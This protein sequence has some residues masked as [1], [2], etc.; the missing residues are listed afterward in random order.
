MSL[1]VPMSDPPANLVQKIETLLFGQMSEIA[2]EIGDG[3]LI[4]CSTMTLKYRYRGGSPSS[5][6]SPIEHAFSPYLVDLPNQLQRLPQWLDRN[7][8]I[9]KNLFVSNVGRRC[10]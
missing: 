7:K 10:Q 2:N 1:G 8:V 4:S 9:I 5:V 3:M 6:V